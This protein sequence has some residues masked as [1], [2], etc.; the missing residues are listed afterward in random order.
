MKPTDSGGKN[1]KSSPVPSPPI[2]VRKRSNVLIK[3][4]ILGA[5]GSGKTTLVTGTF[6]TADDKKL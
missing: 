6:P 5:K 2:E 1:P 4:A 3:G